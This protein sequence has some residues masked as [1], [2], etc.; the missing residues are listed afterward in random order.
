[1]LF[2]V[3]DVRTTVVH[4]ARM[5]LAFSKREMVFDVLFVPFSYVQTAVIHSTMLCL[6]HFSHAT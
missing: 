3:I 4:L 5:L 2:N 6:Y 1:M